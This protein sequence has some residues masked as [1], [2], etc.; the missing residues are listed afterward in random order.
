MYNSSYVES[1]LINSYSWDTAI[2]FI[3][4]YSGNSNYANQTRVSTSKLNTGKAGDK[5]CNIHDMAS[6][7]Y[8]WSTEHSTSTSSSYSYP[9]VSRGGYSDSS[10][11]A[12]SARYSATTTSNIAYDSFRPLCYVK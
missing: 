4:K 10:G 3:Q 7:C 5:V 8:E 11:S 6:N 9:C 1:D 12:T 2:V